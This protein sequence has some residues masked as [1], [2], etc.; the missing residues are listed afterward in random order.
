MDGLGQ[1]LAPNT[2]HTEWAPTRGTPGREV[3][4]RESVGWGCG[5]VSGHSAAGALL[6][7]CL[8]FFVFV[9]RRSGGRE[10]REHF[11]DGYSCLRQEKVICKTRRQAEQL[12]WP[13]RV[14]YSWINI[15]DKTHTVH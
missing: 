7:L 13:M 4:G 14:V 3:G 8:F 1:W 11:N 15:I 6:G 10:I 5:T 12:S 9:F 2:A